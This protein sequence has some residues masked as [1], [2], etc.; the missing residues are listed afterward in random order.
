MNRE[1]PKFTRIDTPFPYAA[2]FLSPSAERHGSPR[3]QVRQNRHR[4]PERSSRRINGRS[5]EVEDRDADGEYPTRASPVAL[6][7]FR[8]HISFRAAPD[9][10]S[11]RLNSSH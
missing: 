1:P 7:G 8:P 5:A 9:R 2:L 4:L 3:R 10:K 6:R 11:T